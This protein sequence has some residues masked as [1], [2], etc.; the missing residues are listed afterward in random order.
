MCKFYARRPAVDEAMSDAQWYALLTQANAYWSTVIGS[1]NPESL[2]A[3]AGPVLMQTA[4]S[5]ASYT[6]GVDGDGNQI[7]PYGRAEI[8][9]SPTGRV[10]HAGADYNPQADYIDEGW[11]IRFPNQRIRSFG[12][13]PWARFVT[14]AGTINATTQPTLTPAKLGMLLVFNAVARWA[15][16]QRENPAE[17]EA[18][19]RKEWAGDPGIGMYGLLGELK[20]RQMT[21][22]MEAISYTPGRWWAGIPDGS[23]YSR[24]P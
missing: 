18:M 3:Q 22:G 16:A 23:G 6:F 12:N 19:E 7:V 10:M 17:F 20:T 4:D 9:E 24:Y 14:E 21:Q 11:R 1:I 13:G 2:Y 5:G 15:R 8:R